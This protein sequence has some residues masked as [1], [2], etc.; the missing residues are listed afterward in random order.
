MKARKSRVP[1]S[2]TFPA[3]FNH[4][5]KRP[6]SAIKINYYMYIT[7]FPN[8]EVKKGLY[9]GFNRF[10]DIK[11]KQASIN[12]NANTTH[13]IIRDGVKWEDCKS[14]SPPGDFIVDDDDGN[15][16]FDAELEFSEG[17]EKVCQTDKIEAGEA[18]FCIDAQLMI[19]Y[20][21]RNGNWKPIQ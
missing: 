8:G 15:V 16:W 5:I 20:D 14:K 6:V 2:E 21:K 7:I 18:T 4:K 13:F 3:N 1:G 11:R 12:R 17:D 10:L 9:I 19:F